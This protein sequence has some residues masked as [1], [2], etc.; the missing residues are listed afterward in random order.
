MAL[1]RCD[2]FSEVLQLGT[3]MTVLL[4]QPAV[5][6]VGLGGRVVSAPPPLLYL[7]HGLSDDA[8]GWTRYT[9]VERHAA[10]RGLAV[11]M[12]QVHR[13]F[14]ADTAYGGRFW[15]FLSEELPAVVAGFFRVS[16]RRED[17][18]VAGLSMGGYGA[19]KWALRQPDR[20]AA[21][22]SLSGALDL[23]YRLANDPQPHN[24]EVRDGVF[25]GRDL[26]GSDDD[27]LHLIATADVARLPALTVYCGTEDHAYPA[28]VRFRDACR[29][30]GIDLAVDFGPGDHRWDYWDSKIK[31]V[32]DDLPLAD[33]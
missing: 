15:T 8:T 6:Q 17:T 16:A 7:L 10:A 5:A 9:S 28:N 19:M 22:V 21:A 12:P 32:I 30:R 27:L 3:S 2:F 18:F 33:G 25:G 23:A 14:Y 24:V 1:L 13:S 20:F 29:G 4:P 11:V 31:K 26:T